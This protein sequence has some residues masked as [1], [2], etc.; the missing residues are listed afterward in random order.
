M[1][2]N[3]ADR[4]RLI[5]FTKKLMAEPPYRVELGAMFP[6]LFGGGIDQQVEEAV[7]G[8]LAAVE[9]RH[10]AAHVEFKL[11]DGIPTLIEINPRL[12]GDQIRELMMRTYGFDAIAAYLDLHLGKPTPRPSAVPDGGYATSYYLTPPRPG[13]IE[14]V[15]PP[16]DSEHPGIVRSALTSK[17][18]QAG[19]VRDNDDRLGYV[20]SHAPTFEDSLKQAEQYMSAVELVYSR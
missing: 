16:P 13:L 18:F 2:D 7:Y 20:I 19:G 15:L 8:W 1:W 4:W 9:H 14:R 12:G 3:Q 10:G 6:Y 11:R 5:G 17:P